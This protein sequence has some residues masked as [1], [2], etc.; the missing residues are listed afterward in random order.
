M[1]TADRRALVAHVEAA[2][3]L[4][5]AA[6][7]HLLLVRPRKLAAIEAHAGKEAADA[8]RATLLRRLREIAGEEGFV[9]DAGADALALVAPVEGPAEHFAQGVLATISGPVSGPSGA[10]HATANAGICAIDGSNG[11]GN[12]HVE[13]ALRALERA[14]AQGPDSVEVVSDGGSE[15]AAADWDMRVL[16]EEVVHRGELHIEYQPIRCLRNGRVDKVEALLRWA[17]PRFGCVGPARFVPILEES[18]LIVPVGE[19][20]LEE[21]CRQAAAWRRAG[22]AV[23]VAVNVSRIQLRRQFDAVARRVLDRTRC[24]PGWIELEI[25]ESSLVQDWGHI[26]LCVDAL[27]GMGFT[28]AIDDFGSGYSSL[29]QLAQMPV[30]HLKLD[31]SLI[32]GLPGSGKQA[33]IVRAVV[34]LAEGLGME[35]TAEGVELP[36]Q[37][38]WLARFPGMHGQGYLYGRAMSQEAMDSML[39]QAAAARRAPGHSPRTS[40]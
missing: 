25:T 38:E 37:S 29:G 39:M 33:R 13:R 12:T 15:R 36:E 32:D 34:A 9:A 28:I 1:T 14:M 4:P 16:L 5:R 24:Q 7:L 21:A 3:M 2:L 8:L 31:R 30:H 11:D 10:L 26:H 17:S 23:R 19:W 6:G 35:L 27:V 22:L 20:V 40:E 18:G